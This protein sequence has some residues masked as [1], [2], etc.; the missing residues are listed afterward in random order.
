MAA[1]KWNFFIIIRKEIGTKSEYK[2]HLFAN[3]TT[4]HSIFVEGFSRSKELEILDLSENYLNCSI[5][6]SLHGFTALR[7]LN[8]GYNNFNC[9][10][11]ALG[12][13]LQFLKHL[14]IWWMFLFS[15]L[16]KEN[17]LYVLPTDF[18]KFNRRL[19]LLDLSYNQIGGSLHVEGTF[20]IMTSTIIVLSN[21]RKTPAFS[22]LD[23]IK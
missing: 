9:S 14:Y 6:T 19:E 5:I 16:W 2:Q 22:M 10:L 1:G 20:T 13:H 17:I 23:S 7:S 18:L 8:L 11:S 12:T 4:H 15:F 21:W 3:L